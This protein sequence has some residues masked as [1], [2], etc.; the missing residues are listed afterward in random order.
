MK[1]K[2]PYVEIPEKYKEL[3]G[4]PDKGTRLFRVWGTRDDL[5]KWFD[6]VTD[7]C[8]AHDGCVGIGTAADYSRVSR[9]AVHK[10]MKEGRITA[11]CFHLVEESTLIK[12]WKKLAHAGFPY[13]F[14]PVSECRAWAE[15]LKNRKDRKEA[16]KE[17]SEGSWN[18]RF[19]KSNLFWR[20]KLKKGE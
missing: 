11:F 19:L 17:A 9:P 15:S 20:K 18:D 10:R 8:R 4:E 6:I 12:D 1:E 14:I 2:I 13:V 7:I 3:I 5:P 16:Q